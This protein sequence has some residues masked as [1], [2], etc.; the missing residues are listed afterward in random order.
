MKRLCIFCF[1]DREGIV[2][3]SVEYL[4][5]ELRRNSDRLLIVVNGSIQADSKKILETYSKD[6][7]VRENIGYDAGAYKFAYADRYVV[8]DEQVNLEYRVIMKK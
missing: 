5:D 7:V 8:E 4:L 6:V 1:F 3:K 2:G